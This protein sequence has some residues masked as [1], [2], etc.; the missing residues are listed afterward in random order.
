[1]DRSAIKVLRQVPVLWI[2]DNVEPIAG[3]P[4]SPRRANDDFSPAINPITPTAPINP[5]PTPT[6]TIYTAAEQRELADF[7][8]DAKQTK[9]KFLLTSRRDERPWLNDL[10]RRIP[11]GPM[12]MHERVQ[13]AQAIAEKHGQQLNVVDD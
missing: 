2:W 11:V 5:I 8:R 7:L 12:P 10:P 6:D 1:M 3:F 4:T 9:A 13:L